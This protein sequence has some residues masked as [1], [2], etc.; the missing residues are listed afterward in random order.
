M[1][2]VPST[3]VRIRISATSAQ[4][5]RTFKRLNNRLRRPAFHLNKLNLEFRR[6][7]RIWSLMAIGSGALIIK[8]FVGM[9]S[10]LQKTQLQIAVFTRDMDKVPDV[11]DS[12]IK[13][14][15]RVPFTLNA[16][17]TSFVRLKAS[18]IEPIIDAQ[19]NGPLKAMA[20]AVAAF[21]G[22]EEIFKRLT[23]GIQQM[24]GKGV[25]SMEELR[26][27]IGEAVPL[28]MRI[29]A[30]QM[31]ISVS[32]LITD[33][34]RG[35]VGVERGLNALFKGFEEKFKGAGELLKNTFSGQLMQTRLEFEKLSKVLLLDSS[36]LDFM[37]AAIKVFNQEINAFGQFLKTP[38]GIQAIEEFWKGLE[39]LAIWAE[40]A[41][42]PLFNLIDILSSIFTVVASI[43]GS[44]PAE[45]VGGGILGFIL[46][47]RAGI[48]VGVIFALFSAELA[49]VAS[50]IASFIDNTNSIVSGYVGTLAGVG[51]AG[52]LGFWLFGPV[53]AMAAIVA[54]TIAG[55]TNSIDRLLTLLSVRFDG[56]IANVKAQWEELLES[57]LT[58][59]TD[60]SQSIRKG[61]EAEA[62]V[63]REYFA[64]LEKLKAG[65][66]E[67]LIG[68][69]DT[70]KE[71]VDS[72]TSSLQK[73]FDKLK[74]IVPEMQKSRAAIIK[75]FEGIRD[76]G[77]L[78]PQQLSDLGKLG[79]FLERLEIT[80]SGAGT[81]IDRFQ[82]TVNSKVKSID[83]IIK[84]VTET[85]NKLGESD[86]KVAGLRKEI[87]D[88]TAMKD[89]IKSLG[90][91]IVQ[92]MGDKALG[93]IDSRIRR[94]TESLKIFTTEGSQGSTL[95]ERELD[96][97]NARFAGIRL[98]IEQLIRDVI[99]KT[100]ADEQQAAILARL[101]VLNDE[102]NKGLVE[103]IKRVR[104]LVKVRQAAA[105]LAAQ[106]A[107]DRGQNQITI[108]E[109][110]NAFDK[111]G[112]AAARA[113][114]QIDTMVNNAHRQMAKISKDM[115]TG[116]I[117]P[118]AG[119]AMLARWKETLDRMGI[120]GEELM[121]RMKFA[122]S[123]WG[124]AMNS[125]ASSME[126]RLGEAIQNV[127]K[128]TGS[129]K[130]VLLS[131]YDDITAA[132]SKYLAK[133]ILMSAFGVGAGGQGA[134]IGSLFTPFGSAGALGGLFGFANG[135][136]FTVGGRGGVDQNIMSINGQPI[137]K[138]SKGE[139]VSISP[140][141]SG[142]GTT[143]IQ[144]HAL[145]SSS[146]RELFMRE[147]SSLV[148]ALNQRTKVFRGLERG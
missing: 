102:L 52:L 80:A 37:T 21:G 85:I 112:L 122:A 49:A 114:A 98:S 123:D 24:A 31:G 25:V 87:V 89:R 108:L 132:L 20:D 83:A 119:E 43:T 12:L 44:M 7:D 58:A 38:E 72:A 127:I 57:P 19:G 91:T 9:A 13:L 6:L 17:T 142:G 67:P 148:A 26:Q 23:I 15:E 40:Q 65:L 18:G 56:F 97:V 68:P 145:D 131:F 73:F 101:N 130:D 32:K 141:G 81:Q 124:E 4:A 120:A 28:A 113:Q 61:R 60:P 62:K 51:A 48:A 1:A 138:V 2:Q 106:A 50:A 53:G 22:G 133:Q 45:L 105:A 137:A 41:A 29:M 59:F 42:R 76:V 92:N 95:L 70:G 75:T 88:L 5:D 39:N 107:L 139:D 93:G 11:M 109:M 140:P 34:S 79:T 99:A 135:G 129:L 47:G 128:G 55:M 46:F 134:A 96:K 117:S 64:S 35:K 10:E 63:Y 115:A 74:A 77:G 118:E 82:A 147:G 86:A 144:I 90:Q 54:T 27:Q 3:D 121:E 30:E 36:A 125:I 146:V 78:S 143:V 69:G 104:E 94:I 103:Q 33:V 66:T 136:D 84:S 8:T 71:E 111:V 100:A 126:N 14:T 16:M 116:L 110:E